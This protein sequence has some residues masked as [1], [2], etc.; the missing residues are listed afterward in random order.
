MLSIVPLVKTGIRAR[1]TENVAVFLTKDVKNMVSNTT[2]N[3]SF[4]DYVHLHASAMPSAQQYHIGEHCGVNNPE[5]A[6]RN[7]TDSL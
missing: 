3:D 2:P 7:L 5:S 4:C 1:F 6:L